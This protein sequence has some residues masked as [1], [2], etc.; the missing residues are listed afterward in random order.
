MNGM[1]IGRIA[2]QAGV[3][4]ETI[5]FYEREGLIEHPPRRAS[6]YRIYPEK[7]VDRIRFIKQAKEL[8]F[9]LKE[10]DDL[11][12]LRIDPRASCDDVRARAQAKVANIRFRIEALERMEHSLKRLARSCT[13][14][15]PV[16]D[17]PILDALDQ[18]HAT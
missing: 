12:S 9:S 6:G 18:R 1:T 17:C 14:R 5:R 8:G 11:L 2:K 3:G 13:G 15:G 4:V 16:R 10:I 7:T